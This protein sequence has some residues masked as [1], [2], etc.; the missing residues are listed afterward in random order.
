MHL[1]GILCELLGGFLLAVEAIKTKNLMLLAQKLYIVA[2]KIRAFQRADEFSFRMIGSFIS[3]G[4]LFALYLLS[5]EVSMPALAI[6]QVVSAVSLI[7]LVLFLEQ[8]AKRLE[9]VE[10]NTASGVVGILG[11]LLFA[12]GIIIRETVSIH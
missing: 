12:A 8:I 4:V 2:S 11:F 6:I 7:I 5:K 10:R 3:M 1:V 9:W